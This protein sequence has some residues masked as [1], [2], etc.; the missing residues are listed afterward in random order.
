MIL[1]QG[2]KFR[3]DFERPVLVW[4]LRLP[5]A[6]DILD[7]LQLWAQV[8]NVANVLAVMKWLLLLT[9]SSVNWQN[10]FIRHNISKKITFLWRWFHRDKVRPHPIF[11]WKKNIAEPHVYLSLPNI[12]SMKVRQKIKSETNDIT[13]L[14]LNTSKYEYCSNSRELLEKMSMWLL[15]GGKKQ[16]A[17]ASSNISIP[18]LQFVKCYL[19]HHAFWFLNSPSHLERAQ[20]KDPFY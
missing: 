14:C 3:F 10:I 5:F 6:A 19:Q 16:S 8:P 4:S 2:A 1:F 7:S 15:A 11:V 17:G 18:S 12:W 13:F 20:K 9:K